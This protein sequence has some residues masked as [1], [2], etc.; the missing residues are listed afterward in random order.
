LLFLLLP[1][2]ERIGLHVQVNLNR[3][4]QFVQDVSFIPN[5]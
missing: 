2:V 3:V 1:I 4:H 5:D